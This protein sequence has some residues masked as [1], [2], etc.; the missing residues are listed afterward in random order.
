MFLPIIVY[1][2]TVPCFKLRESKQLSIWLIKLG[3]YP[4]RI[5]AGKPQQNGRHER[6]HRTLKAATASPPKE[7]MQAQQRAFDQFLHEYLE[8]LELL[9]ELNDQ[10][11]QQ[12]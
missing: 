7:D 2:T 5:A 9:H 11:M 3:I 8:I 6:M 12:N 1:R 10:S 4:E